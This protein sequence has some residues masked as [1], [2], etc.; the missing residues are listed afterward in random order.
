MSLDKN[1]KQAWDRY[2]QNGFLTTF[3]AEKDK[4]YSG[5]V[6]EFWESQLKGLDDDASLVDCAA[7]N[8]AILSLVID[9]MH[10]NKCEYNL[11]A[12]DYANILDGSDFY[13]KYPKIRV[14]SETPM[15][16]MGIECATIDMCASQY[17]FEYSNRSKTV[18]E[19]ARVLKKD[20]K[21]CA[22]IHHI[23]S[24]VTYASKLSIEQINICQQSNLT[25][26][27]ASLLR[28]LGYLKKSN[29]NAQSDHKASTLRKQFNEVA[30]KLLE[31]GQMLPN[32]DHINYYLNELTGVFRVEA[33]NLSLA[34]KLSIVKNVDSDSK[35]YKRR[36]EAM[37]EA[38]CNTEDIRDLKSEFEQNGF[39]IIEYNKLKHGSVTMA[40]KF[41]AKKN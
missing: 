31:R 17:G 15:E 1:K 26:T 33:R 29:K 36:M 19:I 18:T 32:N 27:V 14:L 11:T 16:S 39:S 21:F 7:G 24:P 40:W 20:G 37:L 10:R 23:D 9:Y 35:L 30:R 5:L 8:G 38:T 34:K 12:V 2:W 4:N 6:K 13:K 41:I 28:R 25:K 3:T 22:L